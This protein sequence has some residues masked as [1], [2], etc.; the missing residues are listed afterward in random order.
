M[1]KIE[2]EKPIDVAGQNL[3]Y[4]QMREPTVRDRMAMGRKKGSDEEKELALI[5]NLVEIPED[6]LANMSLKDYRK[7]FDKL[8]D[9]LL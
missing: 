9:F 1:W 5:S 4:I 6:D 8:A 3:T 7:F 2:L